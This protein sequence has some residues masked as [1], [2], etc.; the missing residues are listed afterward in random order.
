MEVERKKKVAI[1]LVE[2]FL[3]D[4][5]QHSRT[6]NPY[7]PLLFSISSWPHCL[8]PPILHFDCL[9]PG[10]ANHIFKYVDDSSFEK[11]I[12]LNR[13]VFEMIYS[14]FFPFWHLSINGRSHNRLYSRHFLSKRCFG[15][16]FH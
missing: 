12:H 4:D 15:I 11:L 6:V 7:L 8:N 16:F 13:E 2:L 10:S 9:I 5:E 14:L 1:L 3:Y